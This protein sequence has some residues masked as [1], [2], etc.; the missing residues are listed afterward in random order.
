M[1]LQQILCQQHL[2][3]HCILKICHLCPKVVQQDFLD[4]F[5]IAMEI[6]TAIQNGFAISFKILRQHLFT[7]ILAVQVMVL[8]KWKSMAVCLN[9]I[10]L[11]RHPFYILKPQQLQ[12]CTSMMQHL[13]K[14]LMFKQL[15]TQVI[16][17]MLSH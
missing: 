10:A 11:E 12:I 3:K 15:L 13:T 9:Q 5:F 6:I 8:H 1:E 7:L 16:H 14:T 17:Q 2:R 4:L